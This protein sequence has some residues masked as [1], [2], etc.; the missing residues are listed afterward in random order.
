MQ[1]IPWKRTAEPWAIGKLAAYLAFEDND[2]VTGQAFTI[3]G[4]L[5]NTGQEGR[6]PSQPKTQ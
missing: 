2:Y 5:M 3:D 1:S 6:K 4:G